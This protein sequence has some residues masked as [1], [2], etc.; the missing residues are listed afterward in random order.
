MALNLS[1]ENVDSTVGTESAATANQG[2][3]E[4]VVNDQVKVD[5]GVATEA[6][7]VMEN[8]QV[9]T[10]V[11]QAEEVQNVV[12]NGAVP[13]L[14]ATF[15]PLPP[16]MVQPVVNSEQPNTPISVSVQPTVL[17][18]QQTVPSTVGVPGVANITRLD[19]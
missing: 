2:S 1:D 18:V 14:A 13:Q 4:T 11:G 17:S 15:A 9:T 5:G 3:E 19:S 7:V 10:E 8:P 6:P 12:V 16:V